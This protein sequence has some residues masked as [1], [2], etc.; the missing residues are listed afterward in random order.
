[1]LFVFLGGILLIDESINQTKKNQ[2]EF[3]SIFYNVC[4]V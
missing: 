1:M 2:Q 4:T 3:I